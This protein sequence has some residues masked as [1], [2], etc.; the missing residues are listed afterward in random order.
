MK[1]AVLFSGG[2]DSCYSLFLATK[3]HDVKCLITISPSK[4]D[5]YMFHFPNINLTKIQAKLMNIPQIFI[6][7][8]T[9][10]E[11]E[12]KDLEKALKLA[13]KKYDIKGLFSGALASNYQKS[14][15]DSIC[16]KLDLKSFSPLWHID[17]EKYLNDL[18]KHKFEVIITGIA[19][20]GLDKSWLGRLIDKKFILDM[21]KK[22]IHL[23]GEGGEYES[24]VLNCPLFIKKIKVLE[25]KKIMENSCT[26]YL[27]IKKISV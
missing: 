26:G 27:K 10:K 19:A 22:I 16:K 21:K 9:K 5:S 14:R 8:A 7:S 2:K 4:Q 11:L 3:Q 24:L 18:I 15:I 23:G 20:D 1:T 12:L 6:K 25:S 17:S 13:I